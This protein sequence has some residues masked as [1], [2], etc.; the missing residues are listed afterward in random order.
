ML[1]GETMG[2]YYCSNCGA[3][4]NAQSGFNV[5]EFEKGDSYW[6]CWGCGEDCDKYTVDDYHSPSYIPDGDEDEYYCSR[7]GAM[8][9]AQDGF[10]A[11]VCE[12]GDRDW[13]CRSC[14]Y[15]C[16]EY[17]ADTSSGGSYDYEA[18]YSGGYKRYYD[19]YVYANSTYMDYMNYVPY[20]S[21]L[22]MKRILFFY[23]K[24]RHAITEGYCFNC[25]K[26]NKAG[27]LYCSECGSRL[28]DIW[29]TRELNEKLKLIRYRFEIRDF[30]SVI[31]YLN[32]DQLK[33]LEEM[34][35]LPYMES[36]KNENTTWSKSMGV[37]DNCIRETIELARRQTSLIDT[38]RIC[39]MICDSVLI[40]LDACI[41]VN[42]WNYIGHQEQSSEFYVYVIEP[43]INLEFSLLEKLVSIQLDYRLLRIVNNH[44]YSSLINL[45]KDNVNVSKVKSAL[46]R[47]SLLNSSVI[48][49]ITELVNQEKEQNQLILEQE[50]RIRL[51]QFWETHST[52]KE[53]LVNLQISANKQIET[54]SNIVK[55]LEQM[56][57]E[58]N[59][60]ICN[61]QSK[62]E[63]LRLKKKS[64]SLLKVGER[65]KINDTIK[66]TLIE[67]HKEE[68]SLSFG[69]NEIKK[70]MNYYSMQLSI[71]Q[72]LLEEVNKSLTK[73]RI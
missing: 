16:S 73:D 18:E 2:E 10:C 44:L 20:N 1:R 48:K 59:K 37:I 71:Q 60:P 32:L 50:R 17:D 53:E 25:K 61:I 69:L 39:R 27:E 5:Y 65:R 28:R 45:S 35:V 7:C 42:K 9:N 64:A 41:D 21:G 66:E 38:N 30:C 24:D 22:V 63:M 62:I 29:S 72:K 15:D 36:I 13:T 43:T 51:E 3:K 33:D 52:L 23:L 70:E 67:K 14:G 47:Y 46:R 58:M 6:T 26:L 68:S 4:L 8:L 57:A 54:C 19:D 34:F 12:R 49:R 31:E 56:Y 40:L 11:R 55:Q